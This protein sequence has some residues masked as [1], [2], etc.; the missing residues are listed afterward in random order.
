MMTMFKLCYARPLSLFVFLSSALTVWAHTTCEAVEHAGPGLQIVNGWFVD[1]ENAVWGYCQHNGWWRPGQRANLTRNAPGEI[2]PN[3]TED[4]DKLTDAMLKFGYPGF[5]HN[6]GLWFDRRRDRHDTGRR[7]DAQVVPPFLEQPWARSNVGTAW[8]GLPKYDLTK[9]NAWYFERLKKFADLC[10]KKGTILIHN[11]YMQ[12]ALL[13]TDAHYVDFPWR[14]TNCI[15]DTQLPDRI[16]AAK[17]FYDL[18]H[19]L[20]RELHQLYIRHCL[21]VLGRNRNVVFL[22]SEEYTGP[23]DFMK[24]WLDTVYQWEDETGCDVHVGLSATK[25]VLDSIMADPSRSRRISVIDLRYWWYDAEGRLQAPPGGQDVAGRFV[26]GIRD[27]TPEQIYRQAREYRGRYRRPAI[28]Q[29]L[30]GTRQH[31]W[32]SLMG[33]V[34]LQVGQMSYPDLQDPPD[35]IPLELCHA[36]QP[37]YDFI[38]TRLAQDL[39]AMRPADAVAESETPTW[40]LADPNRIYLIYALRGGKFTVDLGKATGRYRAE[41]FNPRTGEIVRAQRGYVPG[42]DS[43]EWQCPDDQDWALLLR[44]ED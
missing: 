16:P 24:F 13:E 18:S 40:V 7:Q 43:T 35:Y 22:C 12:H 10:D 6:F 41:W 25:D 2:G 15:Q 39:S 8:D 31:A 9:F 29:G 14:P 27:T 36:I 34:S 17:S 3:R 38:R 33:G 32:A 4:L 5:E 42:G 11:N 19:D 21:D 26:S 37:T 30:V 20:R 28:V 44:R 23:A 1:H